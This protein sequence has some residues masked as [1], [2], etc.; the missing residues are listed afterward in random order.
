MWPGA[1]IRGDSGRIVIG[2]RTNVQD[3]AVVHGNGGA[4]IGDGVTIGHGAVCHAREVGDSCL[5]GNGAV[6]NDGVEI[7]KCTLVSAGSTVPEN[8][9]LP[10]HSLVGGSPARVRGRMRERFLELIRHAAG[11]YAERAARYKGASGLESEGP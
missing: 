9:K 5:I 4:R 2:R 1:V 8:R 6:V 3:N 10:S 7:G 11:E